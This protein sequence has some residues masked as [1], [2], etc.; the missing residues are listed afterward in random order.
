MSQRMPIAGGSSWK[1]CLD[2]GWQGDELELVEA[3]GMPLDLM[4]PRC[5]SECVDD[6]DEEEGRIV[7]EA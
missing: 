5:G 2:C 4:C 1:I 7:W 6:L 3:R